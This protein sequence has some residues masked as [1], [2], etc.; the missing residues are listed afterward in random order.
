M[1]LNFVY[2]DQMNLRGKMDHPTKNVG[3]NAL[4]TLHSI[5]QMNLRGKMDH[6]TKNVGQNALRTLHSINSGS[7]LVLTHQL[8]QISCLLPSFGRLS[9][10]VSLNKML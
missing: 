2:Q 5:Y 8:F 7:M 6:P 9:K 4:R 10:S 1:Y 3:Q